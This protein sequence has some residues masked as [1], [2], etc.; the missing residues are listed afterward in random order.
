V[1]VARRVDRARE[2]YSEATDWQGISRVP[3]ASRAISGSKCRTT[4]ALIPKREQPTTFGPPAISP[5]SARLG[6]ASVG[7]TQRIYIHAFDAASRSDERRNR[8]ATLYGAT[9]QGCSAKTADHI[10]DNVAQLL[11]WSVSA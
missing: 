3:L 5:V 1:A 10:D 6:H 2:Q 7:T 11:G 4:L 9:T 8:L